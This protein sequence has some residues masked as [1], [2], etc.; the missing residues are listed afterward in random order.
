M[1][2]GSLICIVTELEVSF[3]V[4]RFPASGSHVVRGIFYLFVGSF[5]FAIVSFDS[6]VSVILMI[7]GILIAV[8]GVVHLFFPLFEEKALTMGFLPSS[9]KF[10]S[11][12]YSSK[13]I[14]AT[15]NTFD[16]TAFMKA[17]AAA[18]PPPPK[19]NYDYYDERDLAD[20]GVDSSDFYSNPTD[21]LHDQAGKAVA[22]AARD[23]A[24][25][26]QMGAAI[27]GAA[28]NRDYQSRMGEMLASNTDNQYLAAAARNE[29]LQGYAGSAVGAAAQ[30]REVQRFAGDMVANAAED[31]EMQRRVA[32][33][34]WDGTK[35]GASAAASGVSS[36]ASSG[37]GASPYMLGD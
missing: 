5:T 14:E 13:E 18:A 16:P 17:Q 15:R 37:W 19:K 25:Q 12:G 3:V 11:T 22:N 29:T 7:I 6:I 1:T 23:E 35:A 24:R 33:A 28:T 30:N 4:D 20:A 21:Y 2:I 27:G 36:A 32:G 8:M 9:S 34:V 31:K 26:Q 10:A